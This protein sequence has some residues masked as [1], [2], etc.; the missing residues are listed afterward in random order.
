[1]SEV[2]LARSSVYPFHIYLGGL[3]YGR[4]P[5]HVVHKQVIMQRCWLQ[6]RKRHFS[7][8]LSLGLAVPILAILLWVVLTSNHLGFWFARFRFLVVCSESATKPM[9]ECLTTNYVMSH[10]FMLVLVCRPFVLFYSLLYCPS[11]AIQYDSPV[12]QLFLQ[13]CLQ[14][15]QTNSPCIL[16]LH[17]FPNVWAYAQFTR[18]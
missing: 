2:C 3:R 18:M 11:I 14:W 16:V 5:E 13:R 8:C 9:C 10:T 7:N 1:M 15:S 12:S 4:L 17:W 6:V